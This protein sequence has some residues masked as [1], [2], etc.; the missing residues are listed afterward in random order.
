MNDPQNH[1]DE[2]HE[3]LDKMLN[4]KLFRG[5]KRSCS[6]LLYVSNKVLSGQGY[7]IKEFSIAVD[8][9]GL[10]TT[11]DQQ[12]DPRIRVEAKRL[13][14]R[15]KQY[16]EGPGRNDDVIISMTKGSYIPQ[17]HF[18]SDQQQMALSSSEKGSSAGSPTGSPLSILI[19]KRFNLQL[20][21]LMD[22]LCES[23]KVSLQSFHYLL[24]DLLFQSSKFE[25][26]TLSL[27]EIVS[28]QE[29]VFSLLWEI[30]AYPQGDCFMLN[31]KL[32]LESSGILIRNFQRKLNQADLV[33]EE[34][35]FEAA[36]D[37][38]QDQLD[39]CRR[40]KS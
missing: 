1:V 40:L 33:D 26:A 2:I 12:I 36:R 34:S 28:Q 5:A 17:F 4:H 37:L 31:M 20:L 24:V 11:F 10:E 6:F 7:Q 25:A 16:Y 8:A 14:D 3:Q 39:F 23:S 15:L 21:F 32:L 22:S 29:K 35:L 19:D 13:R 30:Q 38:V 9:F 27:S 18:R